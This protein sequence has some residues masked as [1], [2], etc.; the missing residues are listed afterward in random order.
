[1][2]HVE[3]QSPRASTQFLAA[4]VPGDSPTQEVSIP[5]QSPPQ[6]SLPPDS[7]S[8]QNINSNMS[9]I[10]GNSTHLQD[11]EPPLEYLGLLL[12]TTDDHEDRTTIL[13]AYSGLMDVISTSK[14]ATELEISV[15]EGLWK[16]CMSEL[17]SKGALTSFKLEMVDFRALHAEIELLKDHHDHLIR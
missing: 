9:A 15:V 3:A 1:L 13:R 4:A 11:L 6:P 16:I 14:A 17:A 10:S 8:N 7:W 5:S 2:L 12:A